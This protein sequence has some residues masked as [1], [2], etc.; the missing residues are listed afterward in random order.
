MVFQDFLEKSAFA[1]LSSTVAYDLLVLNSPHLM[2]KEAQI[3]YSFPELFGFGSLSV[4]NLAFCAIE[5]LYM[6]MTS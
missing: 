2:R 6:M 4:W 3:N 1:V 5:K